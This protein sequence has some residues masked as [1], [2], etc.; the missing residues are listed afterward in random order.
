MRSIKGEL[1][2]GLKISL[3]SKYSNVLIQIILGIILARLLSPKEF[4]I[5]AVIMIFVAFFYLLADMGIGPAL[6]QHKKLSKD[7][8]ER[9]FFFTVILGI[10]FGIVFFFC[11][12]LIAY[13]YQD[14]IYIKLTRYLSI[15]I[16]FFTM[17]IVPKSIITRN[18]NFTALGIIEVGVNIITGIVAIILAV[19]G[20]SYYS[21]IIK[22]I[23]TSILA[24][25][26]YY[27]VSNI[28]FCV[29]SIYNLKKSLNKIKEFS[30]FQFL[31]NMINYSSR[32][33]DNVLIGKFMGPI[34][35]G[36][37]DIGYKLMLYPITTFRHVLNPVIVPVL[38]DYQDDYC[39]I[40]DTY[41]KLLLVLGT[42]GAVTG[43]M[44]F[45]TAPELIFVLYGR[46]WLDSV[47]VFEVL[48]LSIGVQMTLSSAGSIFQVVGRAKELFVSGVL[49][50]IVLVTSIA[51]G[52]LQNNLIVVAI[53]VVIGYHIDFLI[54]FYILIK[55]VLKQSF[56]DFLLNFK[57]V[58]LF[59]FIMAGLMSF[60]RL[61]YIENAYLLLFVKL[62]LGGVSTIVSL[63]ATGLNKELSM[64]LA[65]ERK[66][67]IKSNHFGG[68]YEKI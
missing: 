18:K 19:N 51:I 64:L 46:K 39:K 17:L 3:I 22:N 16:V 60:S 8:I 1:I 52:V 58:I 21:I 43:I 28:R 66:T 31:F 45:F 41:K 2:K 6:I 11:A 49:G 25:S 30:V 27:Y 40:Y 35:L 24:F 44:L 53:C 65:K 68:A 33:M 4:G 67:S 7:D 47:P 13:F 61:I 59:M 62:V 14:R 38:K 29:P 23:L 20:A 48:A 42:L 37:Y 32:N 26:F 56:T 15:N 34:S 55:F 50:A 36:L 12:E 63:Y 9:I 10:V 5:A 57:K 54:G